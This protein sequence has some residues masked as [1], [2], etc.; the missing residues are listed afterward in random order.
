MKITKWHILATV[1]L[2][3]IVITILGWAVSISLYK[4]WLI[5]PL[6]FNMILQTY[7]LYYYW[8]KQWKE[9]TEDL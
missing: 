3:C 6:F 2:Q 8:H 4:E 7:L 9:R 1:I 5:I